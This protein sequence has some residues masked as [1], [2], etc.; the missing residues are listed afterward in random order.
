MNAKQSN[1]LRRVDAVD[2]TFDPWEQPRP[3][4][5]L[6]LG[7]FLALA[8]WGAL[9]Y[10]N[11]LT[12]N[13]SVE[14]GGTSPATTQVSAPDVD[15]PALVL[16]GNGNTWG[17]AS[18][19][20]ANGEGAGLTPSL[21]GLSEDYLAKQ[22]RDFKSGGRSNETMRYVANGLSDSEIAQVANYYANLPRG[23]EAAVNLG[24]DQAHGEA[25]HRTGDWKRDI[26]ACSSCHGQNGEG[27][28]TQFP[29]LAGQQPEYIFHQL[30]AWKGGYRHNSPQS[31][32]DDIASRLSEKDMR[33]VAQYFGS[34]H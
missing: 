34:L 26:P 23:T 6:V 11:D 10:I 3:I 16:T 25:L 21:A 14:I 29:R 24:G 4:P 22:L 12:P 13:R 18:C 28:G 27:V 33:D 1:K 19:H 30:I 9:S 15:A 7:V 5:L 2:P 32:M 8:V 17:C 31:L 20:G